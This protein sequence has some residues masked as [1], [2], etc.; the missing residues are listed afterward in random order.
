MVIG[1]LESRHLAD[2]KTIKLSLV[3]HSYN[4]STQE[5]ET[6]RSKVQD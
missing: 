2:I 6:G 3:T 4:P 5:I 1:L